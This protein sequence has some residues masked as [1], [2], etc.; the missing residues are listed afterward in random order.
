MDH[1][2]YSVRLAELEFIKREQRT[3]PRPIKQARFPTV[4]SLD[5]SD[6]LAIPP[7]NK[8]L[9]LELARCENVYHLE[10][11]IAQGN[12]KTFVAL[13]WVLPTAKRGDSSRGGSETTRHRKPLTMGSVA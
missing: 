12:S 6:F 10:N 3:M 13:G 7:Y 2:G 5:S 1:T 9:V 11:I 4:Q 8:P